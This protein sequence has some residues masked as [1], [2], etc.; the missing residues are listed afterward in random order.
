MI[1]IG[2]DTRVLLV[3]MPTTIKGYTVPSRDGQFYTIVINSK[4]NRET[5]E[6]TYDHEC[7]HILNGDFEKKL[8]ADIIEFYAHKAV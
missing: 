5:Q 4:L 1:K 3:N 8:Q 7:R 2:L 6:S